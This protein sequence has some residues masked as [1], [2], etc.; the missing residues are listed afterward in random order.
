MGVDLAYNLH[1]GFGNWFPGAGRMPGYACWNG[2][3]RPVDI[4]QK[5]SFVAQKIHDTDIDTFQ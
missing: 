2:S 3:E 4:E 5:R 1:S